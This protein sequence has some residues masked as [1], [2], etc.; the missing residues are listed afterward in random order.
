MKLRAALLAAATPVVVF[1]VLAGGVDIL[2]VNGHECFGDSGESSAQYCTGGLGP[3]REW[4]LNH[5]TLVVLLVTGAVYLLWFA[6]H[7]HSS[8]DAQ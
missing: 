5:W 8:R 6:V 3:A 7:N 2:A 1:L 4:L